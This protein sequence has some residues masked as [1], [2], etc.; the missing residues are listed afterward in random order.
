M[1][2]ET[3]SNTIVQSD[4]RTVSFDIFDTLLERPA[5]RPDDI[6]F[7]LNEPV[8]QILQRDHFDFYRAR[9]SIENE[10][11][12]NQ[13]SSSRQEYTLSFEQIYEYFRIKHQLTSNQMQQIMELERDLERQLLTPRAN[14]QRL[15]EAARAAGK[16]IIC[17]SD[18]Y[19]D[20]QF[21]AEL[22][23][24][25]GFVGFDTIYVSSEIKKRKDT[26]DLFIH[27]LESENL[28]PH[29]M[30]HIGDNIDSDFRIPLRLG[31]PAFHVPSSAEQF[32][33]YTKSCNSIWTEEYSPAER[34]VIGFS[35]NCWS[36]QQRKTTSLFPQKRD[37]GYF[38]IG[39]VLFA[40]AQH[41]RT[42]STIQRN[43]AR[44][45]FASRDGFLPMMAYNHLNEGSSLGC[46][47]SRYLYCGRA[48][49]QAACY[50]DDPKSYFIKRLQSMWC[51]PD[52]TLGHLFDSLISP[53][54][55][56][57][58]DPCRDRLVALEIEEN[59]PAL[60]AILDERH[61]DVDRL[62][63]DK[64]KNLQA[65]Y[66]DTLLFS[67]S[68]RALIFDCGYSGS[69]STTIM[70]VVRG[71]IDKAYLC[72]TAKNR[73]ADWIRK[74]KTYLLF[75]NLHNIKPAGVLNIFEEVFSATDGPCIGL[76]R[77]HDHWD[78]IF[79]HNQGPST[80]TT[81][82]LVA[83]QSAAMDFVRDIKTRFGAF[84]DHLTISQTAFAI[85]PLCAA[86]RASTDMS[87]RHF[88]GIIFPDSFYG[89]GRPLSDKIETNDRDYLLRTPFVNRTLTISRPALPTH[90]P[91]LRVG[92]HVHLY[93]IDM[94]ASFI[95]RL[96]GW[97]VPYDLFISVCSPQDVYT[98]RTYFS[99][100]LKRNA[101]KLVIRAFPNRGRDT[102]SWLAGFASELATYDLAG[103]VHGKKS[104]HFAWGEPWREYLLDN[105]IS[106]DA[107]ADIHTHFQHDPSLGLI[108]PPAYDG[109]FAFW[110]KKHLTHIEEI[111]RQNCQKLLRRMAVKDHITKHNLHF[112][113]G[114]MFWYR[115]VALAP[116]TE[117][118]L[119]FDDFESEPIGITGSLAHAIERLPALVAGHSGFST[120]TY[121]RQAELLDRFHQQRLHSI[122]ADRP[123]I[124][125]AVLP[126]KTLTTLSRF[127]LPFMPRGTR[128][129]RLAQAAAEKFNSYFG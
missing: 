16:H 91:P 41:L 125:G 53:N 67:P 2:L 112:S 43:Y 44:V 54:F 96:S 120:R 94:A 129:Y 30:V 55:L 62:L 105:L 24:Q 100:L 101:G 21:L 29:E 121:I 72:E 118:G 68:Q 11:V 102:G 25:K 92:L 46:L 61:A 57:A 99:P 40:I 104:T 66:A 71:K 12:K 78:P 83:I 15:F 123:P 38:G 106:A 69:V 22:L 110:G 95:K 33:S 26:G 116:L 3:I 27:V 76:Q 49:Y 60:S 65:Y 111:D 31:I 37:V 4:V 6:F 122:G 128:R 45:H 114:T 93:H 50:Q 80:D 82:N 10:A 74:T 64:K 73:L 79:D 127:L 48:F 8:K 98:A 90:S 32:F 56:P 97:S 75:G 103:H 18:M 14:G 113:V 52:M 51:S 1:C 58:D 109:I 19:H 63:N 77:K 89:D 117:L 35:L 70:K 9:R 119:T 59:F 7:L 88:E 84:I 17:L 13:D 81:E 124:S 23:K 34:L 107:F 86:L 47:P 87:I 126:K 108:F 36:G 28:G 5:L 85:E 42:H 115:P 20:S 39:P